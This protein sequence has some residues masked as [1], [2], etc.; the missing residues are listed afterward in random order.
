LEIGLLQYLRAKLHSLAIGHGSGSALEAGPGKSIPR[1]CLQTPQHHALLAD[2]S[3]MTQRESY[4]A[5]AGLPLSI[6][7]SVG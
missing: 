7:R 5:I 2:A 6:E 4:S 1:R 3:A